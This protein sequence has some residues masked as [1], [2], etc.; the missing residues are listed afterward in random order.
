MAIIAASSDSASPLVMGSILIGTGCALALCLLG[1]GCLIYRWHHLCDEAAGQA[2]T[3]P[4]AVSSK[5]NEFFAVSPGTQVGAQID[6]GAATAR[7]SARP[8][9]QAQV[10]ASERVLWAEPSPCKRQSRPPTNGT[11]DVTVF[12]MTEQASES[13]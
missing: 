8:H 5:T 9:T 11:E 10:E 3:G 13:L 1:C 7:S 6:G 12:D 2:R 4:T